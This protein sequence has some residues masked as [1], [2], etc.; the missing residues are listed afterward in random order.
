VLEF[1]NEL[2]RYAIQRA[3]Q[4]DTAEV[5]RCR[6]TVQAIQGQMLQVGWRSAWRAGVRA[7]SGVGRRLCGLT[8]P[9]PGLA[10][11]RRWT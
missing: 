6:D 5:A 4:R 9:P 7:P 10:G 11:V 1:S 2:L 8:W 3:T